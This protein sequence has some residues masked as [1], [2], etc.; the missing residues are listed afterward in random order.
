[1]LLFPGFRQRVKI[2]EIIFPTKNILPRD[3]LFIRVRASGHVMGDIRPL[4]QI[5]KSNG[6]PVKPANRCREETP[7]VNYWLKKSF[8]S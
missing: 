7:V 2:S 1:M 3:L 6:T 8:K 5:A 4:L